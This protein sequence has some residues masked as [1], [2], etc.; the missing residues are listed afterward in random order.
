[1]RA[2]IQI[3]TIRK[4]GL[5]WQ[6]KHLANQTCK[7]FEI[8]LIDAYYNERKQEVKEMALK[9]DLDV[10]HLPPMQLNYMTEMN[11]SSNRNLALALTSKDAEVV[12][13]FDDYQIPSNNF[14]EG[15]LEIC[16]PGT[17]VTAKQLAVY[18]NK[19]RDY[20]IPFGVAIPKD[21]FEHDDARISAG[22][23]DRVLGGSSFWTNNSSVHT[24][25][26]KKG[27]FFFDVRYNGGTAGEDGDFGMRLSNAGGRLFI[28]THMFVTH[29]SHH[30]IDKKVLFDAIPASV[31][32]SKCDHNRDPFTVNQYQS[33]DFNLIESGSL[34]TY[35]DQ[36]TGIKYYVCK[37]CGCVGCIDSIEV[38]N[39]NQTGNILVSEEFPFFQAPKEILAPIAELYKDTQFSYYKQSLERVS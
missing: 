18:F 4:G 2:S 36:Q 15:H 31:D 28:S 20:S 10:H 23:A 39:H 21:E 38:Y 16:K 34:Y 27:T 37:N 26:L 19:D 35:R 6:L 29:V 12:I 9:L 13:F 33:G 24:D 3:V 14:V 8:I 1:M 30:H 5:D 17:A 32:R 7:D 22:Y 25:D 11:Q